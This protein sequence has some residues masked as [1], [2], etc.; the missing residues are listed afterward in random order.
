MERDRG[1]NQ[2]WLKELAFVH[3]MQTHIHAK[4]VDQE[5][6]EAVEQSRAFMQ[7]LRYCRPGD[8]ESTK[9]LKV[10]SKLQ[11]GSA[12]LYRQNAQ[13]HRTCFEGM[14]IGAKGLKLTNMQLAVQLIDVRL[15]FSL[16]S[17]CSRRW[18]RCSEKL[19]PKTVRSPR[20]SQLKQEMCIGL[21]C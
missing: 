15:P 1:L 10:C 3:F 5:E 19:Q 12:D 7:G 18:W 4:N 14:L 6:K 9:I 20:H 8:T 21:A 11:A 16:K 17:M 2:V 13:G